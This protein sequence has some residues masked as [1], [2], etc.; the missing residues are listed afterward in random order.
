[1]DQ[2]KSPGVFEIETIT[3]YVG[4]QQIVIQGRNLN[5]DVRPNV[6][7]FQCILRHSV[8]CIQEADE[9]AVMES[10]GQGILV[11]EISW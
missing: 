11:E 9:P 1:M 2:P 10:Q 3:L 6:R 5:A 7:L 8:P 4:G